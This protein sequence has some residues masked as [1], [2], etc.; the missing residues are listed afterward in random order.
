MDFSASMVVGT[1]AWAGGCDGTSGNLWVASCGADD[2]SLGY[3][4]TGCGDCDAI[5]TTAHF[6]ILPASGV[7]VDLQEITAV[8]CVPDGEDCED[9]VDGA[10]TGGR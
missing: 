8:S 9:P 2:W 4:S 1:V 6:A 7:T 3:Y 5:W 10:P